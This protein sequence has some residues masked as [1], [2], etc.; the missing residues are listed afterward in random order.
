MRKSLCQPAFGLILAILSV[1]F[2]S[3]QTT[4]RELIVNQSG[5]GFALS[6]SGKSSPLYISSEDFPG[7]IR[8]CRDLQIDIGRVTDA[9]PELFTGKLPQAKQAVIAVSYTHLT[10]PTTPY[11]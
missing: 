2:L 5:K 6:V 1:P 4:P 10:L 11:V 7:V 9:V 8:A 3:A